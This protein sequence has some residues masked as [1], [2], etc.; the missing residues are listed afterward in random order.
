[1][2]DVM[3]DLEAKA[4]NLPAKE[5]ARL[6]ERLISSLDAESDA[7]AE[8]LWLEEAER[9]LDELESGKVAGIPAEEVFKKARSTLR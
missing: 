3:R 6:A 8:R 5:R 7:D 2:D 1:M 4:L 9:R